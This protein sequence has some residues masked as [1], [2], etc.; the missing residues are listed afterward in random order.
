MREYQVTDPQHQEQG[1]TSDIDPTGV[2]W[3]VLI[4]F[5]LVWVIKTLRSRGASDYDKDAALSMLA[6]GVVIIAFII[7]G[8]LF[9]WWGVIC[10]GGAIWYWFSQ[11][12]APPSL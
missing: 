11:Q 5:A 8:N 4:V 12:K 2:G 6:I 10:L 7:A 1:R 3:A 9:G